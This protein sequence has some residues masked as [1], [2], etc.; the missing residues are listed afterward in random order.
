MTT[1]KLSPLPWPIFFISQCWVF[2]TV[3]KLL[4]Y[5]P[6]IETRI[7]LRDLRSKFVQSLYHS[8]HFKDAGVEPAVLRLEDSL[9]PVRL[10]D[11]L[12][13]LVD[14]STPSD[15]EDEFPSLGDI[16][17]EPYCPAGWLVCCLV[18]R[19]FIWLDSNILYLT[20]SVQTEIF[21]ISPKAR[22][23]LDK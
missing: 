23:S 4:S 22:K 11:S 19:L 2:P 21:C 1:M 12:P 7:H 10:V 9:P 17:V 16:Q 20:K 14:S 5:V 18:R 6:F 15:S 3:P 13:P 8:M